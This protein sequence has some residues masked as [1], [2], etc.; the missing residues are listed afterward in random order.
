M[1]AFDLSKYQRVI[2]SEGRVS[3]AWWVLGGVGRNPDH[4]TA[5]LGRGKRMRLFRKRDRREELRRALL[6]FL[7]YT[8]TRIENGDMDFDDWVFK[9]RDSC[10]VILGSYWRNKY[11][12]FDA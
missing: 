2:G 11:P 6:S 4:L 9:G 5:D 3:G 10:R 1:K 7:A 12:E 8:E